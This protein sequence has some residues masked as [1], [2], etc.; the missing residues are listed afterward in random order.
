MSTNSSLVMFAMCGV[1]LVC[2]GVLGVIAFVLLRATGDTFITPMLAMLRRDAREDALDES[3]AGRRAV[4]SVAPSQTFQAKAQSVDFDSAVE[5]YRQQGAYTPGAPVAPAAAPIYP[6]QT[7]A[8]VY[9]AQ[10]VPPTY[11]AQNAPPQYP[12]PQSPPVSPVQQPQQPRFPLHSNVPPQRPPANVPPAPPQY[13]QRT[14]PPQYP[15]PQNPAVPPQL[16]PSAPP[17]QPPALA[18]RGTPPSLR[19]NRSSLRGQRQRND[20]DGG[21]DDFILG[22]DE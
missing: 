13:P 19:S 21:L 17:P 22:E 1:S 8:P 20:D 6:A 16:P 18:P 4:R 12:A 14:A 11:P 5:K 3:A 7:A 10:N 2:L 9:P 15:A